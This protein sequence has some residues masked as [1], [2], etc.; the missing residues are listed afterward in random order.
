M[1][2]E[3]DEA[4]AF[5]QSGPGTVSLPGRLDRR[6]LLVQLSSVVS[7]FT[8]VTIVLGGRGGL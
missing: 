7:H 2:G 5:E 4:F 8:L 3:L 1:E 6:Y